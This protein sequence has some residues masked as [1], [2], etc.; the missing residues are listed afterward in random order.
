[1]DGIVISFMGIQIF[2]AMTLV[3]TYD[4][5]VF[6]CLYVAIHEGNSENM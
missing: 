3:L 6:L 2:Y 1:M 5:F 4:C